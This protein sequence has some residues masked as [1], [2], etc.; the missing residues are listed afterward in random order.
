[1][2]GTRTI[3]LPDPFPSE[4]CSFFEST[5]GVFKVS[6]SKL[7]PG[8]REVWVLGSDGKSLFSGGLPRKLEDDSLTPEAFLA[9]AARRRA[10]SKANR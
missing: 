5:D 2:P 3:P 6:S 10:A 8:G 9:E 4:Y 7:A 1:M